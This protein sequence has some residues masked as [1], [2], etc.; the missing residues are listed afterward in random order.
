[1]KFTK[2]IELSSGHIWPKTYTSQQE[3]RCDIKQLFEMRAYQGLVR[4]CLASNQHRET[5]IKFKK[6]SDFWILSNLCNPQNLSR[7]EK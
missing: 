2:S 3:V 1:M 4:V 5:L 7:V 6:F